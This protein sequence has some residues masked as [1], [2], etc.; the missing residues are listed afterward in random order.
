MN[1]LIK[2]CD[3]IT[4]KIPRE[5]L[6]AVF[7]DKDRNWRSTPT[8]VQECIAAT[9][10]RPRVLVDCNLIGGTKISIPVAACKRH[11]V[12]NYTFVLE[13]PKALTQN[14]SIIEARDITYAFVG[15]VMMNGAYMAGSNHNN[16]F[17]QA[18]NALVDSSASTAF[19]GTPRLIIIG[20]NVIEVRNYIY[21]PETAVLN[22][23][24][25]YDSELSD[26][27]LRSYPAFVRA[28][29]YAVKSHIYN[30]YIV[31]MDM[32]EMRGGVQLGQFKSII[33]NY[34]E[35]EELYETHKKEVLQKV[36]FMNDNEQMR[37][38]MMLQLGGYR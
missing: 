27:Q 13:V 11:A 26:L 17:T 18:A 32:G 21:L 36:L 1:P 35:A 16:A 24:V 5:I 23:L 25:G 29:E 6:Q 28:C 14:R 2:A 30:E 22:C 12:D 4:R 10:I 3:D 20:E 33:D 7:I 37:E 8:T 34:S 15:G 38:F 9:V 31:Y 19:M